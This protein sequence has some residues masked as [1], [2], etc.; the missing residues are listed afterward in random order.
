MSER[1]RIPLAAI[2]DRDEVRGAY[3]VRGKT[4]RMAKNG[5][6][7][8][9]LQLGDKSGGL[10]GRVWDNAEHWDGACEAGEIAL[11]TGRGTSF[12][13]QVQLHVTA[14]ERLPAEAVALE[15]F[16][17]TSETPLAEM[18]S[19]VRGLVASVENRWVRRLLESVL[20]DPEL[21][22]R[23]RVATAAKSVH[24][25]YLGGLMEHSLSMALVCLR[26]QA[27]YEKLYPGLLDRDLLIAGAL[28]HDLGK[29]FEIGTDANFDYTSEGRLLGHIIQGVGVIDEKA[30]AIEGFPPTL[31][32]KVKH[33]VVAHHGKLEFGS[34]RPPH[35]AEALLL[36]FVDMIDARMNGIRALF[37]AQAG[38]EWTG[39]D[40]I[41]ES[42]FLSPFEGDEA[43][44]VTSERSR[45]P[46][47][48]APA[49]GPGPGPGAAPAPTDK[50]DCAG[51]GRRASPG[52]ED[53]PG[54]E[55]PRGP[56][57]LSLF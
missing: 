45:D 42:M 22:P 9:S 5:R 43:A 44:G 52:T 12:Q 11:I 7:Y 27:H 2:K 48:Y 49:D 17:P 32:A 16:M 33:M 24:H 26:L 1:D 54:D 47:W 41:L 38:K 30:R 18:E 55:G 13:G 40:R 6:A 37:K 50:D 3:L 19:A 28:L 14:I 36:H 31:L 51:S 35:L 29:V 25:A 23:F 21:G 53:E 34:P 39:F 56:E 4:L 46:D 15:D 57:N 10:E 20:D 8:L